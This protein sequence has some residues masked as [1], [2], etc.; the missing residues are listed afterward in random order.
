METF[1]H[2][3]D[4]EYLKKRIAELRAQKGVTE[5]K[6]SVALGR[7]KCYIRNITHGRALPSMKDFFAICDYLDV[8]PEE[9]FCTEI[10]NPTKINEILDE[11]RSFDDEDLELV[12][13]VLRMLK[14]NK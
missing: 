9:F 14:R 3:V 4:C 10:K 11:I 8:S 12:F 13:G 6:M 2:G 5:Y 7:S 1:K